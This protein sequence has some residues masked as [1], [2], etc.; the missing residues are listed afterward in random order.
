MTMHKPREHKALHVLA[1]LT[2]LS[3]AT[4]SQAADPIFF[5]PSAYLSAADIPVNF[6]L[7]GSPTVLETLEDGALDST[8][9]GDFGE[10][11]SSGFAGARD[12]VDVDDGLI[13]GS[14]R[15]QSSGH[16]VS[17]FNGN[18]VEGVTFSYVGN[19]ALPTAFGLVWTDGGGSITFRAIGA[20]GQSLGS[21]TRSGFADNRIDAS[22]EEDR[23]FGV[24][25]AGGIRSIS[26][27]NTSGGIEVDHIQ[28]GQMSN[29]VP[30]PGTWAL[31]AAGLLGLAG[32]R[33]RVST[34][35]HA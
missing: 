4:G 8:L 29:P 28:Y 17:W 33:R 1:N 14:C 2:L 31:M 24:Q 12:S 27:S 35:S 15:Q 22:T 10:L 25:F 20:N 26:I 13:D 16:C 30:E 32:L 21:I 9:G 34:G 23:F 3:A 6:Y 19:G 18:G 5:G 11:L 7:G